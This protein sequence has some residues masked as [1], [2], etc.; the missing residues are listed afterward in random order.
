MYAETSPAWVSMIG[1]AVSEPPPELLPRARVGDVVGELHRALQQARVQV[2]DVARVGLAAR[3][4]A[5]Q[6]RHLPVGVGV[7]GEVVVHAQRVAAVVEEVLAHR[8]ARVGRHELDRRGLIR[9]GGDDDR[10]FE[11][12]V[13]VECLR[14]R[15]DGRHALADRDVHRDDAGVAVVDD[16]VDR[17]RGLAGLTVA[18]DQLALAA[19]DRDH[20]VDRLQAGLHRFLHRLALHDAGSLELG[21]AG[22]GGVHVTLA[23]Q[24]AS[25]RIDDPPEQ[26]LADGDL[27]QPAGALDGVALGDPLPFAEQHR[28]DVVG[29][30]VE[31]KARDPVGQ[32]EHLEGHAVLQAVQTRDAVRHREHGADLG[33]LRLTGVEP[34]DAALQNARYLVRID[35]HVHPLLSNFDWRGVVGAL[36]CKPHL[37]WSHRKRGGAAQRAQ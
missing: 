13:F 6:Q 33:E 27:E 15:D 23:V 24:R 20:R 28:A 37:P 26:G 32:L 4:T 21:R 14:E 35:L 22:L 36:A 34:L 12:A 2:E 31:R 11:R 25:E 19:A 18:D 29:L 10:V 17:D 3:R 5:Q 30:E 8:A 9:G 16:R 1:S 7:L